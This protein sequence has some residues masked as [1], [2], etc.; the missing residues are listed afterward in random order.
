MRP[1]VR[2]RVD[3]RELWV[4][5]PDRQPRRATLRDLSSG[6]ARLEGGLPLMA[7]SEIEI[8]FSAFEPPFARAI[9]V[10]V[11]RPGAEFGVRW[12][13]LYRENIP[14]GIV[15]DLKA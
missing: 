2:I 10:H 13:E 6:G 11:V 8:S 5:L 12:L 1:L 14:I 9:V 15:T 3:G 7:G 4:R